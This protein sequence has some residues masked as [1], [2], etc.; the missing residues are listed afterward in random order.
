MKPDIS[1]LSV[2]ELEKLTHEAQAL[3]ESKKEQHLDDAYERIVQIA[4]E[5][6]LSLDAL[7]ARGQSKSAKSAVRK[8]VAPRYRNPDDANETW[9]GRGKQP[10][11]LAAKLAAGSSLDD[12]LI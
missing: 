3:I 9:T 1:S 10:R 2:L 12:F 7:V 6:G 4:A 8:P 5:V 11:W